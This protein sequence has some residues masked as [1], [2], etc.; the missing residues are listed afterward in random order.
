MKRTDFVILGY[1]KLSVITY[2]IITTVILVAVIVF[3][4]FEIPFH[5]IFFTT[6]LGQI[7]FIYS[8]FKVLTDTYTTDKTFDDFYEDHPIKKESARFIH[9]S[10]KK[11]L[12]NDN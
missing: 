3:V 12:P 7:L 11:E 2:L 5:I 6:L 1:M 4:A 9:E 8:I 10:Q